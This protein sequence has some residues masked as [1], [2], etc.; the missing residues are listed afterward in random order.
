MLLPIAISYDRIPEEDAFRRELSG[1]PRAQMRLGALMGWLWEVARGR[2][3]LGRMH[4]A[5]AEPVLLD[6]STDLTEVGQ[7]VIDG[8]RSVMAVTD[9]H[10]AVLAGDPTREGT[11]RAIRTASELGE[12]RL[13]RS[14]LER[15]VDIDPLITQTVAEHCAPLLETRARR[16]EWAL[17]QHQHVG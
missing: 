1:A 10:V 3:Q 4:I 6:E 15:P 7:R 14:V 12:A 16:A 2:V 8:M 17:E 9:F 13:L 5:C 11:V